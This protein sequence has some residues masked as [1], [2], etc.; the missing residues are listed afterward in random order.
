M[1]MATLK[2]KNYAEAIAPDGTPYVA[3]LMV[4][5]DFLRWAT[6]YLKRGGAA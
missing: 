1:G 3:W 2:M 6:K 4:R 5:H